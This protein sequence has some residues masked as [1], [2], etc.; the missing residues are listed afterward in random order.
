[1]VL[2]IWKSTMSTQQIG[3]RD[4]FFSVGGY[5]LLAV[6]LIANITRKFGVD[7]SLRSFFSDPT[8]RGCA[9]I[10]RERLGKP[11]PSPEPNVGSSASDIIFP[12]SVKGS[13]PPLFVVAG[14]Y[15]DENGMYRH[16]SSLV[17]YLGQ[18]RPV[19]CLRP[20]GL[21]SDADLYK[22]VSEIAAEYIVQVR[23][24]QP[25][26]PYHLIGECVGGIVAYE[27]ARQLETGGEKTESLI[28]MDTEYPH[29]FLKRLRMGA[30]GKTL[31]LVRWIRKGAKWAT[32]DAKSWTEIG[33]KLASHFDKVKAGQDRQR[34]E[35]VERRYVLLSQR[36]RIRPYSGTVYLL[37]NEEVQKQLRNLGWPVGNGRAGA[38]SGRLVLEIIRGD[39]VS[40]LTTYGENT[41]GVINRILGES[42]APQ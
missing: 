38:R 30:S 21:I 17:H 6:R 10:L 7:I 8:V 37:V 5:S 31:E 9:N 32:R 18:S 40:R 23:R 33:A 24:V 15:A 13:L 39:H 35:R 25:N 12:M 2:S 34:F 14:V 42:S 36:Y 4:D 16:L 11:E 27:M 3:V 22:S 26:G 19:W 41:S 1:M 28:L 29:S 20:R